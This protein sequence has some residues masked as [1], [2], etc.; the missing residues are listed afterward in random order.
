MTSCVLANL[1]RRSLKLGRLIVLQ[2]RPSVRVNWV[3]CS[4]VLHNTNLGGIESF[5]SNLRIKEV[6]YEVRCLKSNEDMIL[7]LTGQF[8]QFFRFTR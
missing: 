5:I 8:K 7:A 4:Y 3:A 2:T 1:Q 6:L